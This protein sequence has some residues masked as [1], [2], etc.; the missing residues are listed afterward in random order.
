M[1]LFL[2]WF[3]I[4]AVIVKSL[5]L[6]LCCF[7]LMWAVSVHVA[8]VFSEDGQPAEVRTP[9]G[10]H[11]EYAHYDTHIHNEEIYQ[12]LCSIDKKTTSHSQV[13]RYSYVLII[14]NVSHN[15]YK[16]F[17]KYYFYFLLIQYTVSQIQII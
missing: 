7:W 10:D 5:F 13:C 17:L 4:S 3:C 8:C 2:E 11:V 12:D 16:Y 1:W 9:L 15:K 14:V 6:A